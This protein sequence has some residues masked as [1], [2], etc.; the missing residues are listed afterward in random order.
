MLE[1]K[2]FSH[3]VSWGVTGD[4]FVVHDPTEFAKT[5]LPQH[6][7]HNNMASFVRQLNKYDF[8]KIK[9]NDEEA[10][11]YNEQRKIPTPRRPSTQPEQ[12]KLDE[13]PI[14][15]YSSPDDV[16]HL[17][18][19]HTDLTGQMNVLSKNCG[20]ILEEIITFRQ[21]LAAQ[22]ILLSNLYQ[23][24]VTKLSQERTQGRQF[25][26]NLP[27]RPP[28][29]HEQQYQD[30]ERNSTGELT[31]SIMGNMVPRNIE[32]VNTTFNQLMDVTGRIQSHAQQLSSV[33]STSS[34]PSSSS[35]ATRP[36]LSQLSTNSL[37]SS[38]IHQTINLSEEISNEQPI[39]TSL[40]NSVN[41]KSSIPIDMSNRVNTANLNVNFNLQPGT[42][43]V[44]PISPE[45]ASSF[46]PQFSSSIGGTFD[47][48]HINT[49]NVNNQS[50]SYNLSQ[51]N[52]RQ[53]LPGTATN[54]TTNSRNT[55]PTNTPP[56]SGQTSITNNNR[57]YYRGRTS[58]S[59]PNWTIQPKILI[60]DNDVTIREGSSQFLQIFRCQCDMAADGITA[61]NKLQVQHYDLVFMDIVTPDLDGVSVTQQIR[62][63]NRTIP[64]I[65]ML[66]P[67]NSKTD[68]INYLR[69]GISDILLKPFSTQRL[70]E[71]VDKHSHED[72]NG[73]S[74]GSERGG[75]SG[76]GVGGIMS[77]T[78]VSNKSLGGGIISIPENHNSS[79][80]STMNYL[81]SHIIGDI[82]HGQ[83]HHLSS[84]ED[85][86]NNGDNQKLK[87]TKYS[88]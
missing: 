84:G 17:T 6:F 69:I 67:S 27:S 73:R 3:I 61:V 25:Q 36:L 70:S 47:T 42:M 45:T 46:S 76:G 8:H 48:S 31:S 60:V 4:T 83:I 58:F 87:K 13:Q 20:T 75:G 14:T 66:P 12:I 1:D 11:P 21:N 57:L 55:T 51:I 24:L 37:S 72:N 30:S 23:M 56:S 19:L 41:Y 82:Y 53:Y 52:L 26:N 62:Q 68:F 18:K 44:S 65:G 9:S 33:G 34:P 50:P 10:R 35:S 28:H 16:K 78:I 88:H 63:F 54:T 71:M 7:K 74:G 15:D 40:N 59:V 49:S 43:T 79:T 80:P 32:N 2:T 77:D 5:I 29:H 22:D 64:I 39:L 86:E 38:T 85:D 81:S